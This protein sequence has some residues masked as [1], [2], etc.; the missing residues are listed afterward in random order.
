MTT[1]IL[2]LPI[3]VEQVAAVVKQMNRSDLQRLLELTPELQQLVIGESKRSKAQI[4]ESVRQLQ[5]EVM[6]MGNQQLL[7]SDSP[8]L[9]NMTLAQYHSSQTRKKPASGMNGPIV[10][11]WYWMNK[12]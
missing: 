7:E 11:L 4:A 6:A 2:A 12:R 3:S 5:T 1:L 10:I 8:F 9:G